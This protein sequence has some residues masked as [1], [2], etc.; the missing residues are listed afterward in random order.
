MLLQQLTLKA[1]GNHFL[2]YLLQVTA[3]S[4][5]RNREKQ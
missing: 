1:V 3:Q 4:M 5:Q 2:R